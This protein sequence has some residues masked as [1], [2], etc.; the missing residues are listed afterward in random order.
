LRFGQVSVTG[1][2][3]SGSNILSSLTADELN[4]IRIGDPITGHG[5]PTNTTVTAKATSQLTLSANATASNSVTVNGTLTGTGLTMTV[6]SAT[7]LAAGMSVTGTWVPTGTTIQSI[8][9]TAITLSISTNS[10]YRGSATSKSVTYNPNFDSSRLYT[11][12]TS[13]VAVGNIVEGSG[14]Y[15]GTTVSGIST[16]TFILLNQALNVDTGDTFT[17]T[18]YAPRT[19][20]QQS[21]TFVSNDRYVIRANASLPFGSFPGVGTIKT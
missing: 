12:N 7:G 17:A 10:N 8:S 15:A 9:G 13:G 20:T 5:L 18:F 3:T 4:R 14:V 6:T 21:Y 16:N 2:V 19:F 11:G 1:T